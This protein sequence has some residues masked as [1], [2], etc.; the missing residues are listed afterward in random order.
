MILARVRGSDLPV[1]HPAN[2]TFH[3]L[4]PCTQLCFQLCYSSHWSSTDCTGWHNHHP[5]YIF[6]CFDPICSHFMY[7]SRPSYVSSQRSGNHH[8]DGRRSF[9][10]RSPSV[11]PWPVDI[12][13]LSF[14]F[15][16]RGHAQSIQVRQFPRRHLSRL[17][18][19]LLG[20]RNTIAGS[21]NSRKLAVIHF[22]T[23]HV[24]IVS[25]L[26]RS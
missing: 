1:I 2:R 3:H 21:C 15:H 4:S 25:H 8:L 13:R 11:P 9:R 14:E 20:L 6:R 5:Y 17:S 10:V 16:S 24:S 19:Y 12:W 22:S 7:P 23:S 18:I 26:Y